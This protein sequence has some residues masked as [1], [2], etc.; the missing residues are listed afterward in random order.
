MF[1]AKLDERALN[2]IFE[3]FL[4]QFYRIEKKDCR[5]SSEIIEWGLDG[6]N[7]FLLQMKTDVSFS[8]NMYQLFTY[9]MHQEKDLELRGILIYLK[10]IT[11]VDEKYQWS[12]N[13]LME[14]MTV[15]LDISWKEIFE[16]L[17]G[18]VDEERV[19]L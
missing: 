11:D 3:K 18:V 16:K 1:T 12:E 13:I 19:I 8:H 9:L 15:D 17:I 4:F 5:V 2:G 14:I 7:A 10:N 6:N